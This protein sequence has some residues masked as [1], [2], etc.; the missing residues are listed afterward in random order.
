MRRGRICL[1]R[2]RLFRKSPG[3]LRQMQKGEDA[4][5]QETKLAGC[6]PAPQSWERCDPAVRDFLLGFA[7][8]QE[9][10]LGQA[11]RGVYLH[12]SLAMGDF[13]PQSSDLDVLAVTDGPLLP[14]QAA[15]LHRAVALYADG[16]PVPGGLEWSLMPAEA[17]RF[18]TREPAY[19]LHFSP[20][21]RDAVLRGEIN[22]T[23][24]HT[25]PDLPAHLTVARCRGVRLAGAPVAEVLGEVPWAD[26]VHAAVQD[27]REILAG[28]ALQR[29]PCYGVLNI[30]RV[31]QM[32][33]GAQRRCLS[34]S[35]GGAWGLAHLPAQ[36]RPLVRRA[37]RS[38]AQPDGRP[39]RRE[40]LDSLRAY[41]QAVLQRALAL[42]E[43][44]NAI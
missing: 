33:T 26:Y 43:G 16:C 17:G 41:A 34:K 10:H 30:C 2:A 15:A 9:R 39:W 19:L 1:R 27:L 23:G 14:P 42:P 20:R 4:P 25:D 29:Q 40:A 13:Y 11:L 8:L 24:V 36:F 35:E 7:A 6:P 28:D 22:Y 38:R 32:L 5:V 3:L 37:L 44:T 12:G 18:P 31:L 21:W